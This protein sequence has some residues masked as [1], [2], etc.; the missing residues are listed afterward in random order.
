MGLAN[1]V[2]AAL[3]GSG[4][5]ARGPAAKQGCAGSSGCLAVTREKK[6]SEARVYGRGRAASEAHRS[7]PSQNAC[8]AKALFSL[9]CA[10]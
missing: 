3:R 7:V 5:T 10:L 1:A 9:K 8:I 2:G 4:H 6:G